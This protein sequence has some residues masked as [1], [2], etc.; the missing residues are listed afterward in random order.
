MSGLF[1][2]DVFLQRLAEAACMISG[3]HERC[4]ASG[5]VVKQH[6]RC[7]LPLV[8]CQ[9]ILAILP[10]FPANYSASVERSP[11]KQIGGK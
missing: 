9:L 3:K 4:L 7:Q 2:F 11:Y 1:F 10:K 6:P 5:R 8:N